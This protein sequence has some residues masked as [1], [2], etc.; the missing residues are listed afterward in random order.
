MPKGKKE[1]IKNHAQAKGESI[2]S[3]INRAIDE[4]IDNDNLKQ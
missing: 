4:A 2:N 1:I 3:F